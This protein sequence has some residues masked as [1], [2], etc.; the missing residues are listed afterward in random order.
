MR[1]AMRLDAFKSDPSTHSLR[2]RL[3]NEI[4]FTAQGDF[5]ENFRA[6]FRVRCGCVCWRRNRRIWR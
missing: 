4:V 2:N 6:I 5:G 3:H 1:L